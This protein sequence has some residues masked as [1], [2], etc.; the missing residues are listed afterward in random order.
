MH[1]R[2]L[3]AVVMLQ[4]QHMH[5]NIMYARVSEEPYARGCL[6]A[7]RVYTYATYAAGAACIRVH[8]YEHDSKDCSKTSYTAAFLAFTL[9]MYVNHP[10]HRVHI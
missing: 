7:A 8:T 5:A 1:T 4:R 2:T 3:K 9:L 6:H 10:H